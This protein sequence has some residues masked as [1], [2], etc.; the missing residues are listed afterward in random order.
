MAFKL[1]KTGSEFEVGMHEG[2]VFN[3]RQLSR[4][5]PNADFQIGKLFLERVAPC[6]GVTDMFVEINDEQ[7]HYHPLGYST[8][9]VAG[10]RSVSQAPGG[11]VRRVTLPPAGYRRITEPARTETGQ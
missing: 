9:V 8:I 4:I 5:G 2:E 6:L 7:C 3:I 11:T 1:G 10:I